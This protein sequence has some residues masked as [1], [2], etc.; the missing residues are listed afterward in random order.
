[1]FARF[2]RESLFLCE[3]R[4]TKLLMLMISLSKDIFTF[5]DIVRKNKFHLL[6]LRQLGQ[7]WFDVEKMN[8]K[9]RYFYLTDVAL[10]HAKTN[11]TIAFYVVPNG[12]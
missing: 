1:M 4:V 10:G 11:I 8:F 2:Q 6:N 12:L 5:L 7:D 3:Q 9:N